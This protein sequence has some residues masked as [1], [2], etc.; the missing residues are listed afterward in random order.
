[1]VPSIPPSTYAPEHNHARR[2]LSLA[3]CVH[4][5][6][7]TKTQTKVR[8]HHNLHFGLT[9]LFGG[10]ERSFPI[11]AP[12]M[13]AVVQTSGKRM[14]ASVGC[15]GYCGKSNLRWTSLAAALALLLV[16]ILQGLQYNMYWLNVHGSFHRYTKSNLIMNMTEPKGELSALLQDDYDLSDDRYQFRRENLRDDVNHRCG[17]F[18]CFYPL[19]ATYRGQKVAYLAGTQDNLTQSLWA[20]Y[21]FSTD[22]IEKEYGMQHCTAFLQQPPQAVNVSEEFALWMD[23]NKTGSDDQYR[24]EVPQFQEHKQVHVQLVPFLSPSETLFWG[25]K[26]YKQEMGREA[27]SEWLR[28]I[29]D[30]NNTEQRNAVLSR[31]QDDTQK[32]YKLLEDHPCLYIDFQIFIRPTGEL[33]HLDV[34]R[35]FYWNGRLGGWFERGVGAQDIEQGHR[36]IEDFLQTIV[37]ALQ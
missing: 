12:F 23:Q 2:V 19:R 22:I 18:K 16:V 8:S 14:N 32:L 4:N 31:L 3:R 15:A 29:L 9:F 27:L 5:L 7:Q 35:G 36:L 28:P 1:M 11:T 17:T 20:A 6:R 13:N 34:D 26:D 37:D 24:S 30:G 33:V 21:N 25:T 10:R